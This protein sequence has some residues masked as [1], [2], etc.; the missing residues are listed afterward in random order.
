[1]SDG[2][3]G[4]NEPVRLERRGRVGIVT[5]DRPERRNALNLQVKAGIVRCV[6]PAPGMMPTRISGWPNCASSAATIRS[7]AS[8]SSQPPPR[9]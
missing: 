1:M 5:I 9:A 6:P 2:D 8:A 3:S 4:A 7:H